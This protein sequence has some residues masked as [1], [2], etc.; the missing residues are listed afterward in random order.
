MKFIVN[1][2][3]LFASLGMATPAFA[4]G[5]LTDADFKT[6]SQIQAAGGTQTQLLNTSKIYD[7][8]LNDTLANGIAGGAIGGS[9]GS[10]GVE[11]LTNP[12]FESGVTS[13]WTASGLTASAATSGTNLIAGAKSALLTP[14]AT[15]QTFKSAALVVKGLAGG[16][17]AASM[18]Y[19]MSGTGWTLSVVDGSANTLASAVLPV[20]ASGS[21]PQTVKFTCPAS[22][23]AT[24][25]FVLTSTSA[26]Q[27]LAFDNAHLGSDNTAIVSN[28]NLNYVTDTDAESVQVGAWATY[29][30]T[31]QALPVTGTGGTPTVTFGVVNTAP[32]FG[33]NSYVFTHPASNT[34]GQGV[35]IPFTIDAGAQA[36]PL[37]INIPYSVASGTYSGGTATTDSDLEAYVYDVTNAQV[38]Q[39]TAFK[40]DCAVV[41]TQCQVFANFQSASNS[42]SYR[43]ILHNATTTA[44]A[45]A[46]KLD[47][48][49]VTPTIKT[50]GVPASDFTSYSLTLGSTGNVPVRGTVATETAKWR[51]V[52]DSMEIFYNY[53]QTAAGTNAGGSVL[54]SLPPGYSADLNKVSLPGIQATGANFGFGGTLLGTAQISSTSAGDATFSAPSTPSLYSLNQISIATASSTTGAQYPFGNSTAINYGVNNLWVSFHVTVPIA[55]WS[56][57]IQLQ[58][59]SGDS[60]VIAARASVSS[61]ASTTAFNPINFNN[62]EYDTTGSITVSASAWKFTAVAP[63]MYRVA[64]GLYF[65]SATAGVLIYKNGAPS[66]QGTAATSATVG[67]ASCSIQMVAGDYID[68]RPGGTGTPTNP[69]AP[70]TLQA[71]NFVSIERISGNSQTA[72][73]ESVNA[74]YG[75]TT[76]QSTTANTATLKYDTKIKDTHSAYN[77]SSGLFTSTTSGSIRVSV[78]GFGSG[79]TNYYVKKNGVAAGDLCTSNIASGQVCSGSISVPVISGDTLGIYTS[80]ATTAQAIDG[81]LGYLNQVTF[82]RTGN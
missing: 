63:G 8:T 41:G 56:S 50:F 77:V 80:S 75:L 71:G 12:T 18:Y 82:E 14:T 21:I 1:L 68:V 61:A 24:V 22:A 45:Y 37:Q 43:L 29:L 52:G 9:G 54:F 28:S 72:I 40:F 15:G 73:G 25:Q 81:T 26:T 74:T 64:S 46:I 42:T 35:A 33:L 70:S 32:L 16:K 59:Q 38:I 30:N 17:C 76:A 5:R 20:S 53:R 31:A 57:N 65:G 19:I 51:R 79:Q 67:V 34:Q 48:I 23:T 13:G 69:G 78:V 27:T 7:P 66:C 60:R 6:L 2:T 36:K 39:P 4:A 62:V 49:Q 11:L 3:M 47:N 55:G 44:Q 10:G 58:D